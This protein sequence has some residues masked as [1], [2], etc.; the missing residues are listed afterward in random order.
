M[1]N[2]AVRPSV[3]L[4]MDIEFYLVFDRLTGWGGTSND[5]LLNGMETVIPGTVGRFDSFP[6]G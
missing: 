5:R 3:C 4:I 6:L 2:K 1:K